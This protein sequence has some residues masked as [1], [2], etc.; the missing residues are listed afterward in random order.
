MGKIIIDESSLKKREKALLIYIIFITL[1]IILFEFSSIFWGKNYHVTYLHSIILFIKFFNSI[2]SILAFVSCIVLYIRLK[3]DSIF[4]ISLIYLS[5]AIG[6]VMGVFD[7]FKFSNEGLIFLHYTNLLSSLFKQIII[8]IAIFPNKKLKEK[9]IKH[10]YKSIFIVIFVTLICS[11]LDSRFTI[12]DPLENNFFIT[13]SLFLIIMYCIF[14]IILFYRGIKGKEY[15]FIILS[16]SLFMLAMKYIYYLYKVNIPEF[17]Q[18]LVSI[19]MTFISSGLVIIASFVELY[20]YMYKTQVLNNNLKVFYELVDKNKHN[21][22][23]LFKENGEVLYANKKAKEEYYTINEDTKSLQQLFMNKGQLLDRY[24][25]IKKSVYKDGFWKGILKSEH[26]NKII[27]CYIQIIGE[28]ESNK[29]ILVSYIDISDEINMELEIEKLKVYD[30]EKNE[31]ICNISHELRT[32]LNIFYSV[33]QLLD[34]FKEN[35]ELNFRYIYEKYNKT[36][37]LNCKRMMRLINNIIDVS[38]IDSGVLK[39]NFG[40]YNIVSVV[41]DVTL[42]VV[43]YALLKRINIH[44]DTNEE[45]CFIKCDSSMI[46]R[47]LLNILSNAIKFTEENKNIYVNVF[48]RD[49]FIEINIKDEGIGIS[50]EVQHI[51]FEKFIQNDKS[52]NRMNE[53][54]GIGLS[55]V[56]SILVLHNGYVEV[57]SKLNEGATFK[58]FLPNE[59]LEDKEF[60]IYDIDDGDIELELS[61]I[62]EVLT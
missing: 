12:E 56:K 6:I 7:G 17:A 59:Y 18:G 51:I 45:E 62:Y 3:K 46:Q 24:E 34:K 27:D 5:M 43:R 42:S 16:S 49:K 54:S 58:I 10:K 30:K 8:S 50:K 52:F 2:L 28:K 21:Y 4:I 9:I 47:A 61:D 15:S 35:N 44:F 23:F 32:P 19:S 38:K 26:Q 31:F 11:F 20:M 41:E 25:E 33:I 55:I 37:N 22:M 36:L 1:G 39:P 40:N 14:S 57:E 53:G 60:K 29:N 48:V 13:Y